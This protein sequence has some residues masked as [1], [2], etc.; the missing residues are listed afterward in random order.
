MAKEAIFML[1]SNG[2]PIP[3]MKLSSPVSIDG[4]EASARSEAIDGELVR[5]F[6]K[7]GTG[8]YITFMVGGSDVEADDDS[9]PIAVGGEMWYPIEPGQQIAIY[10]GEAS[11]AVAGV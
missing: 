10:G 9:H 7:S 3:V 11:I 6:A 2:N 4:T 1:D 8:D 5:I